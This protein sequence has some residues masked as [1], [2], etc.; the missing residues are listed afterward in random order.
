[1]EQNN[2]IVGFW[3]LIL[4]ERSAELEFLY[5]DSGKIRIGYGRHLWNHMS[6]WCR[7]NNIM[8]FG[9]SIVA[10]LYFILLYLHILIVIRTVDAKSTIPKYWNT[11]DLA[12]N[13]KLA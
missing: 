3:G 8:R 13:K 2:V 9:F 1:M 7:L 5:V 10:S 6:E 4:H 12:A 11:A